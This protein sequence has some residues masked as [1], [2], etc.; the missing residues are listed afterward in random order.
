M[1][2]VLVKMYGKGFLTDGR[3]AQSFQSTAR[4]GWRRFSLAVP[5]E[6]RER[7]LVRP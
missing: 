7:T 6:L 1:I 3:K 5:E 2:D 4:A